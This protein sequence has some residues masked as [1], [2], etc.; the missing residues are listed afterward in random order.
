MVQGPP[1]MAR[2]LAEAYPG[3]DVVVATSEF[4]DPLR[5]DA[6][7]LNGGRTMLITVGRRGKYVGA[8]GFYSGESRPPRFQLVTLNA[9]YNGPATAMKKLI[10]DEYRDT[11]R[12]IGVVENFPRRAYVNG[13]PGATFVGAESCKSCHPNTYMKWS[14]TKHAQAFTSLLKAPKPNCAFDAECITCHTTGFEYHTGWRSESETPY[15][16]GNQCE[17]CHG[18]GSK[19]VAEPDHADYRKVMKLTAEQADRQHLC[20]RCH[21]SDNSPHFEFTKY[22]SQIVHKAM[23]DYKDPK[24]HRGIIPKVARTKPGTEPK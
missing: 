7:P 10:E 15:L 22:Y 18:P 1:A 2:K 21:D 14:T 8:V 3:F 5:H 13:A 16:A 23:D 4:D 19:H 11:L 6:E 24:V 17:N 9:N 12:Q 20:L